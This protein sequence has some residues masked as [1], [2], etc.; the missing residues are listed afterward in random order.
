MMKGREEFDKMGI[1]GGKAVVGGAYNSGAWMT[2]SLL[3]ANTLCSQCPSAY[4]HILLLLFI[5]QRCS[6]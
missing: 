4:S 1:V 2:T 5:S 6:G 3:L